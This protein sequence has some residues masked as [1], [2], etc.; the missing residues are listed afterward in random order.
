MAPT[1]GTHI[2]DVSENPAKNAV[3]SPTDAQV[4]ATDTDRKI[5]MLGVLSAFREGKVPDNEQCVKAL[6]YAIN[7][8]PIDERKLSK[9]GQTLVEDTRDV[10]R[11]LREFVVEKNDDELLQNFIY[12]T[13]SVRPPSLQDVKNVSTGT[14]KG[15][16]QGDADQ[17]VT[18]LRTLGK[19]IFTNSEARKL[20]KDVGLLARDVAADAAVHAAE[21]ARPDQ[22]RLRQVDEPAPSNQWVGPNG[23]VRDQ[24]STVPDTGLQER[25]EQ[26]QQKIGEAQ[27]AKEEAKG[28][29]RDRAQN[30][31]GAADQGQ[32]SQAG[33][34]TGHIGSAGDAANQAS[35]AANQYAQ[36][37]A[38]SQQFGQQQTGSTA[39]YGQ[40]QQ[41][42]LAHGAGQPA[43]FAGGSSGASL[44][45]EPGHTLSTTQGGFSSAQPTVGGAA[46]GSQDQFGAQQQQ[47]G[48]QQAPNQQ[49]LEEGRQRAQAGKDAGVGQAK[50]ETKQVGNKLLQKIPDEH[51]DRASEQ[52]QK[53]KDYLNDK[54]PEER[55]DRFIYRLKK[56]IVENQRHKDY[57]EAIDFFLDRA[58]H[59]QV[60]AKV[61]GQ[62]S[63]GT[64]GSVRH[65]GDFQQ[66]TYELRTLLERFAN[67]ASMG[68]IF[69]AVDQLYTD[70][71][72][73]GELRA[74]FRELNHYIR[75]C[76][77]EPGYIMKDEADRRG[78]ELKESGKRYWD[79]Q[80]GKYAGHKDRFFDE[81]QTFFTS[82]A[83]DGL[84]QRLGESVK[85]LVTDLFMNS[86]GALTYKPHLWR[87]IRSVI[88][89]ALFQQI[90]YVPIPRVE[91][92]SKD[93]DLVIE[94][95]TLET[96]NLLPNIFEIEARNY[97]KLSAFDNLGDVSKHAF[98]ISFSQVQ[99]DLKDVAFYIKKKTGFP[100]LT[101]SGYADVFLGG[102]GL[103]GK[104]QIEST[105][106]KHHAFKVVDVKLKIDK[107]KF[108]VR[109]SK[110]STLINLLRP[111]ATGL[112]KT[113]VTKAMEAAIRAALEQVD[114]QLSDISERL[115]D[116]KNQ[117]GTNKI[118]ALKQSFADKK[119]EAQHKKQKAEE[120]A[121]DGKFAVTLD[122]KDKLVNWSAPDSTLDKIAQKQK[123]ARAT[124][125]DDWRSPAF[126]IV[127]AGAS[128]A[129]ARGH[130][131][132]S[133]A[134]P[135]HQL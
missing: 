66:A 90:G 37:G 1:T 68:G 129:G 114:A 53:G 50:E 65:D 51:K 105:G 117:E 85:T 84:N 60:Q 34:A 9:D 54:F 5:K 36:T 14:D 116:A 92:T 49:Q 58:E 122:P 13:R 42:G 17:A 19:L 74:W 94:N 46:Y 28:E 98:W 24:H 61:A 31:A 67:G 62:Q 45:A 112:I 43:Y 47:F 63:G 10:I 106:R 115:D 96:A 56:V 128:Q 97:F 113:A 59:Y 38:S 75:Q 73:D 18:H 25:K 21:V 126:T 16:M 7:H 4:K 132:G 55:R 93:V 69:D 40:Q 11:V 20:L 91:Y 110:H 102:K 89:P 135:A 32:Q 3:T 22:E 109:D 52:L 133:A 125:S 127:G 121:P 2:R 30:V 87:D 70:S 131:H 130:S 123:Q 29:L 99:T 27:Q 15:Q 35:H 44:A 8:S 81:V 77:Q 103:S 39:Q 26:A 88:L 76:L 124:G 95:L 33:P 107:L 79:P 86:E 83:D 134:Q 23:E 72:N 41:T 119:A 48:S 108:A 120:L 71:Q 118:D 80:N 6:D 64:A 101:D 104:V 100:R 12:H 82:Y 57:Q 111:L 78:R